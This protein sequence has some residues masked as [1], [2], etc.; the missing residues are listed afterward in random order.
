VSAQQKG[1]RV[2]GQQNAY[3]AAETK[4]KRQEIQFLDDSKQ[5]VD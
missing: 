4:T 3:I 1:N 2:L 5:Q